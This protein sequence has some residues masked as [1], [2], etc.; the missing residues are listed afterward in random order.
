MRDDARN[1]VPHKQIAT[2]EGVAIQSAARRNRTYNLF[3]Q[4]SLYR[5]GIPPIS[6]GEGARVLPFVRPEAR[7]NAAHEPQPN[8]NQPSTLRLRFTRARHRAHL[9]TPPARVCGWP[10]ASSLGGAA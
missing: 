6:L 8:C 9:T 5:D 7:A 10:G 3:V 4:S 1:P 2:L